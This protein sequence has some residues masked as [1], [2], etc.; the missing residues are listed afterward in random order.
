MK[1]SFAV[2]LGTQNEGVWVSHD[3]G[4]QWLRSMLELPP[5]AKA[6]EVDVRAVA[7]APDNPTVIWAAST[8]EPGRSVLLRSD[9]S[10]RHFRA[11]PAPL[12]GR[13]VWSLAVSPEDSSTLFLGLR[14]GGVLRSADGGATWTELPVKIAQLCNAGSTR[15]T[16]IAIDR[17]DSDHIWISVEIDGLFRS[18]DGGDTWEQVLLNNGQSL[19]GPT[20]VWRD[21]RHEDLHSVELAQSGVH[22]TCPIGFFQSTD[23]GLNWNPSRYPEPSPDSG[24]I[25]YSRGLLVKYDEPRTVLVGVGDYIPGMRGVI[26]RSTDGG[27]T[28]SPVSPLTNSVVYAI[29][30]HPDMPDVMAA[31]SVFGQILTSTD[32]GESWA[33]GEREFGETRAIAVAP[34]AD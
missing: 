23:S 6:G 34:N 25:W 33:K 24:Q 16:D 7:F 4:R 2:C 19:L 13:E 32:G 21:D 11:V 18:T 26:Q 29:A 31:C 14:P 8:G 3:G 22:A 12:D 17:E 27:R 9:D 28:F 15:V 30:G 1:S 10:G 5:Y 20:E